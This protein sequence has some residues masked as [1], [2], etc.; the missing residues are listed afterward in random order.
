LS[1]VN[2][3]CFYFILNNARLLIDVPGSSLKSTTDRF[4]SSSAITSLSH[5]ITDIVSGRLEDMVHET[6]MKAM[7][8][9][10]SIYFPKVLPNLSSDTLDISTIV[11]PPSRLLQ[12]RNFTSNPSAYFRSPEQAALLELMIDRTQSVLAVLGTGTGKTFTILFQAALQQHYVTIVVLPLSSLHDD[13]KRRSAELRVRYSRWVPSEKFNKDVNVISVSIEHLGFPN[14]IQCVILIYL[15]S[16]YLSLIR[17]ISD[18]EHQRR[19]GPIV[20]DEIHKIV[21]DSDYR[22]AFKNFDSLRTVKGVVFGLT[23][24]LPPA[25]YSALCQL[26]QMTWKLLRTPSSRKE[27]KYE[28][29]RVVENQMDFA[30]EAHLKKA[31]SS[32]RPEDRAIVFCRSRRNA[33]TLASVLKVNPYYSVEDEQMQD[34]NRETMRLWVSGVN[35][36]MVSTSIL[37]CGMD[38]AHIRDVIH[39]GPSFSMLDQYQEDSRGGRDGLECRATTFVHDNIKFDPPQNNTYDLGARVLFDSMSDMVTCRR[40]APTLFLDGRA[41]QCVTLP[42]AILCENCSKS[43]GNSIYPT[44]QPPLCLPT[45]DPPN[46]FSPTPNGDLPLLPSEIRLPQ[47]SNDIFDT[48]NRVNLLDFLKF[49]KRKSQS[50]VSSSSSKKQKL[51]HTTGPDFRVRTST[52]LQT[53]SSPIVARSSAFSHPTL[54]PRTSNATPSTPSGN[55]S[56]HSA[57]ILA[58]QRP[59]QVQNNIRNFESKVIKPVLRALNILKSKCAMCWLT[60][61]DDWKGHL[62]DNCE[63]RIGTNFGDEQFKKFRSKA[64][65]VPNGWCFYCLVHQVRLYFPS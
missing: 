15:Y 7:A 3:V 37:G 63:R 46:R 8:E 13:L 30:I 32:Y 17:F 36:V 19:L 27:L 56:T 6:V 62:S 45:S 18:L 53:P 33:T 41:V 60:D 48:P 49:P 40:M 26:T 4:L 44:T 59:L 65:R 21:T 2:P 34:K 50:L 31:V 5:K 54:L 23:G 10:S 35:K 11:I 39:R 55:R 51:S 47:P 42:G 58:R 57:G 38:Y 14:F 64:F 28:V 24:S 20:F 16:I 22:S 29:V 12:L 52:I 25:L 61:R 1:L 9:M 43:A